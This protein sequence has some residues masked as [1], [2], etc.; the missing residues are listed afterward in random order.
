MS[1]VP[2]LEVRALSKT[3]G[4][5]RALR[6]AS[7]A[8]A[9]GEIHGLVGENGSGKSTLVKLLSGYHR[10]DPG[11]A[12]LIDGDALALPIAPDEMRR[13]GLAVVHQDLGLVD[14]FSVVENMRI[15]AMR[16]RRL[17]RRIRWAQER[18]ATAA[19]IAA[20][21]QTIDLDARVGELTAVQR[22]CVA[23]GR[24][25][26]HAA[27]GRGLV[28]FDESSRA[29][30]RD[31][32]VLFHAL[33]R[34]VARR[35][36][37]V[38]LVSHSIEE[39][40]S[41]C[42]R[43]TVLRDGRVVGAGLDAAT[44]DAGGLI[45]LM[46]GRELDARLTRRHRAARPARPAVA[47]VRG[48]TGAL[49]QG[50][51]LDVAAGEVV[52]VTGLIGSGYEELPYLIG[53]A[54]PARAGTLTVAGTTLA[55]V[56]PSPRAFIAAGVALVPERRADDGL[57]LSL[58]VREN[59]TLPRIRAR[60]GRLFTGGEWQREEVDRVIGELGVRPA[61]PELPVAKL[62]GGNQQK[63]LLGK[64]LVGRP[65]LLALHEPTQGVDVGAQADI[66]A[67]IER[68]V[69]EGCGVLIAGLDATELAGVCDRVLVIRE[70][71]ITRELVGESVGF[72]QIV[73][74]VYGAREAAHA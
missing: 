72:D 41:L 23:I 67:V 65:R 2:R 8:V 42:D 49:L 60:G 1:S 24:A 19:A 4:A 39:V 13:R 58:S 73:H 16:P 53:G 43:V 64:W 20:L 3:F 59:V 46:L 17:S 29:L 47:Q 48:L 68:T 52:G 28:M 12:V 32:L 55:L 71:A 25:L 30:P 21:G 50:V 51:D 63:V 54:K 31:S 15:G 69:A 22:A 35:G 66:L 45:E 56:R 38:L 27:P 61:A 34:D 6:D 26:Q 37:A 18:A 74:A 62:S 40:V 11:G 7:L 44:L 57:A 36:G 33:V 9:P 5:N 14:H 10:P 70:G